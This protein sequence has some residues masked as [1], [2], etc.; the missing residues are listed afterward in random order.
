MFY[1][2]TQRGFSLPVAI[3][4]IVIMALLGA[5]MVSILQSGQQSAGTAV[6]STRAFFAAQTG[7][8]QAL[9][10]LFPLDGSAASCLSP[11]P[12]F[13]YSNNG[14]AGC[15]AVVSC[16]SSIIGSKTYYT[17]NS[18]GTCDVSSIRA[19]RQILIQARR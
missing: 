14:L 15:T 11:Y 7:A 16:S 6:M 3:F 8:Q 1:K 9:A 18:T 5:A 10:N 2:R 13:N 12:A 4:I 19:V 17:L